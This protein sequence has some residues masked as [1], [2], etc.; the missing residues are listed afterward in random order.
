MS[1]IK[2]TIHTQFKVLAIRVRPGVAAPETGDAPKSGAF[3]AILLATF[4]PTPTST[5]PNASHTHI[6]IQCVCVYRHGND[7]DELVRTYA[8]P[9]ANS[10]PA[11]KRAACSPCRGA[12]HR[13]KKITHPNYT[14]RS[15][16]IEP[17]INLARA[18]F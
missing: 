8:A 17:S 5:K 18:E 10:R 13:K 9:I 14:H 16:Q 6:E 12:R 1:K 4:A 11:G 3:P 2:M 15:S 7:A